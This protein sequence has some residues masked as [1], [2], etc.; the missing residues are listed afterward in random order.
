MLSRRKYLQFVDVLSFSL[1]LSDTMPIGYLYQLHIIDVV[2]VHLQCMDELEETSLLRKSSVHLLVQI[3]YV[4][5]SFAVE[6]E[7]T[8]PVRGYFLKPKTL[9]IV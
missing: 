2:D 5:C 1:C 7:D 3:F 4:V 9:D 8:Q 6:S